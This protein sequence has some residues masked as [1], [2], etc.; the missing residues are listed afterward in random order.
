VIGLD[1]MNF[2]RGGQ[3]CFAGQQFGSAVIRRDT[4]VFENE[5]SYE[6]V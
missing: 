3:I 6:K 5:S 4:D 1:G 2:Y